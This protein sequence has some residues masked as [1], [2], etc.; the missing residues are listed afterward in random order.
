MNKNDFNPKQKHSAP[1]LE[2]VSNDDTLAFTLSPREGHGLKAS[3][4]NDIYKGNDIQVWT[5]NIL[6]T[7]NNKLKYCYFPELHV[8]LSKTGRLHLHGTI[9]IDNPLMFYAHD[10]QHLQNMGTYN[11][12]IMFSDD[13]E[14]NDEGNS[15]IDVD[16]TEDWYT[17]I[18]KQDCYFIPYF[19]SYMLAYPN[20]VK[21]MDYPF[22]DFNKNLI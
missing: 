22:I 13:N 2:D 14:S 18:S 11:I 9:T 3:N 6:C 15:P 5:K 19:R 21:P 7:L 17:Y 8:E 20:T 1:N 4:D 16:D 10:I 12:K